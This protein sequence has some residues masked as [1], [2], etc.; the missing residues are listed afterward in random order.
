MQWIASGFLFVRGR[1][2]LHRLDPRARLLLTATMFVL[3]LA[4]HVPE[5]LILIALTVLLILS[6]KIF[7]RYSKSMLFAVG[8]SVFTF[9]LDFFILP[10][11]PD[12]FE[13]A[14]TYALRLF[15]VVSISSV[16]FLTTTPDELELVMRWLK[17]PSDF[18]M[19]FVIAVRFVPVLLLDALQ[20]MDAQR[21]RGLEFD[22]GG[23]IQRARNTIPLLVP[24]IA[25][26]VN[27]SLD[28][29]EAMDSRA[30]GAKKEISS[31]YALKF[32]RKDYLISIAVLVIG[33]AGLYFAIFVNSSGSI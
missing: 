3:A 25:V 23:L 33:A 29:A 28:L 5:L 12:P 27:R 9:V 22:K 32:N 24:L 4:S 11:K 1:T 17:I 14:L 6:A 7:R 26:A 15:A 31:L 13:N 19:I 10:Q 8:L 18:V 20:I 16:Y 30:Y 2:W 21:S